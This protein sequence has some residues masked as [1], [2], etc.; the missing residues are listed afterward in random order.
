MHCVR[1]SHSASKTL[2]I[3]RLTESKVIRFL[4]KNSINQT[5]YK[6]ISIIVLVK[7]IF[8]AYRCL[9]MLKEQFFVFSG[10]FPLQQLD[11]SLRNIQPWVFPNHHTHKIFKNIQLCSNSRIVLSDNTCNFGGVLLSSHCQPDLLQVSPLQ[12]QVFTQSL[13]NSNFNYCNSFLAGLPPCC[14][15]QVIQNAA[16][17]SQSPTSHT[18]KVPP[19]ASVVLYIRFKTLTLVEKEP[20][21]LKPALHHVPIS[22]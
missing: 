6:I 5:R 3:Y 2:H 4:Q 8:R 10:S 14:I 15:R 16:A 11:F 17:T 9:N 7:Y 22:L 1:K 21:Y 19:L 12:G 20:V 18:A 13:V